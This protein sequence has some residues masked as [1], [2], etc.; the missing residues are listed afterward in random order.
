MVT[1]G[2]EMAWVGKQKGGA[3]GK[4]RMAETAMEGGRRV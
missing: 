3:A 1:K 4:L 2:K